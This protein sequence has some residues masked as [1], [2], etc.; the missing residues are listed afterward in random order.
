[1]TDRSCVRRLV[2]AITCADPANLLP[3]LPLLG[4][5]SASLRKPAGVRV[6]V[7]KVAGTSVPPLVRHGLIPICF[8]FSPARLRRVSFRLSQHNQCYREKSVLRLQSNEGCSRRVY[9][10]ERRRQLRGVHR[11]SQAVSAK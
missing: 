5:V 6:A 8:Q 10:F 7:H 2:W 11:G 4:A 9:S 3:L 1:M